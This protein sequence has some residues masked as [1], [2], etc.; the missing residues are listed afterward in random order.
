MLSSLD[1]NNVVIV[2]YSGK[3]VL[4]ECNVAVRLCARA[5]ISGFRVHTAKQIGFC[6]ALQQCVS[7]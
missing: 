7:R 2:F 5:G 6:G 3:G 4:I 1:L